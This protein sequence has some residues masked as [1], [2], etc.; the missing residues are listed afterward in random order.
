MN[1]SEYING[2]C[3][4][5]YRPQVRPT[6]FHILSKL[7]QKLNF[8][9]EIANCKLPI[10]GK[11]M[12]ERIGD[13]CEIPKMST[14]AIGAM[15]NYGVSCMPDDGCFINVGVWHG[16][17]LLAGMAGNTQKKCIGVDNFSQFGGPRDHFLKR[18]EQYKSS[19]HCF[20]DMDYLEYFSNV[21]NDP[22]SFY[23]YDGDHS[24]KNQLKGLQ[25]AEPFFSRDCL[26]LIDDT[27]WHEPRQ[28]TL[29]FIG[30]SSCKYMIVL[31]A[32][33]FC[34]M[35]PTLWN[36]IMIFQRIP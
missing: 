6:G 29:D 4:R 18:F 30:N 36:G 34:E 16:F 1:Y 8:S 20:Y 31:D 24:Y 17:S 3:F 23:I 35:H 11:L 26:I 33:T 27:N 13:L 5:V 15:I 22:I 7:L 14:Y 19:K 21:H 10:D 25:I 2:I 9:L 32:T 28:A 12:K